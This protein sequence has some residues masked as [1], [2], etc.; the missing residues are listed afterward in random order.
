MPRM[1]HRVLT[2]REHRAVHEVGRRGVAIYSRECPLG[3]PNPPE[4]ADFCRLPVRGISRP[5]RVSLD[6]VLQPQ[7]S[8]R[9]RTGEGKTFRRGEKARARRPDT[10]IYVPDRN[11]LLIRRSQ[12]WAT[13]TDSRRR[14]RRKPSSVV[15]WSVTRRSEERRHS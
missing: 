12:R 1:K 6:E 14:S 4:S 2:L 8:C 13:R 9:A 7:Y 11:P 15:R 5:T 10:L 3:P